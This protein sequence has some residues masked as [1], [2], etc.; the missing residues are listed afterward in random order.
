MKTQET[1]EKAIWKFPLGR[2]SDQVVLMPRG[3]EILTTQMQG[4]EIC[5]WALV[6]LGEKANERRGIQIYGTGH[7]IYNPENKVYIGTV[8]TPP[9]V[10][11]VFE[12]KG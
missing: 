6:D 12:E 3:A 11:H 7:T 10:W 5:I 4:D 8:Q 9:Y 2:L 1:Q